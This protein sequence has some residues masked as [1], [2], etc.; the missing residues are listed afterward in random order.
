M[1][2]VGQEEID[3][4]TRVIQSRALFRYGVGSEC[5][6]FAKCLATGRL[7]LSPE[8][9]RPEGFSNDRGRED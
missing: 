6:R 4:L 9:Q 5:D 2:Q 1:Y 8:R 7:L 3:A